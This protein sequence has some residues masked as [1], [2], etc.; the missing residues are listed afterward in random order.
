MT[1]RE[2]LRAGGALA[3]GAAMGKMLRVLPADA[4]LPGGGLASPRPRKGAN[5]RVTVGGGR[6]RGSTNAALQKAVDDVGAAGGGVVEVPAGTYMMHDALHLRSGVRVVGEKGAILKKVPSVSS[7]LKAYVGYGHYEFALVEPDKFRVGMGV[8]LTDS[9]SKG[10][11]DTVATIIGRKGEWFFID[12][13]ANHDYLGQDARA[14]SV[15]SILEA[16]Q[17]T[18]AGAEGLIL[19]GNTDETV[20]LNGCRGGG[21]FC[22]LSRRV[23]FKDIEVRNYSGDG[24]SFQQCVDVT[25]RKCRVHHCAGSGL[26][27]GSGTV[28]Y[29]MEQNRCSDNGRWGLFYCLRTTHAICRGNTFT[30][31]G[32]AGISLG[33]RDTDHLIT[34]NKIAGNA[35]SGIEFRS[36][37]P[38]GPDRIRIENN[39][40]GPNAPGDDGAEIAIAEKIHDVHVLGNE[41]DAGDAKALAVGADCTNIHFAGNKVDGR[42]QRKSDVAGE[43]ALVRFSKPPSPLD[44]GPDK[45]PL[46]GAMHLNIPRLDP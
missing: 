25:V 5:K 36:A 31:N 32:R 26:H 19:D 44:L 33:V 38:Y 46:D 30:G 24:V 42:R 27:P 17:V 45:L 10:F 21:V 6:Y 4:A 29:V 15:F 13:M 2:F 43:A 35:A 8:H 1:R 16:H 22:L 28:R 9:Q 7:P 39:V 34:G 3:G 18:D 11:Y 41:I 40:I 37:G 20:E 12:R 23:T 14:T